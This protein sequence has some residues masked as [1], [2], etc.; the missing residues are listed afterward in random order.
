MGACCDS[1]QVVDQSQQKKKEIGGSL[2]SNYA[3]KQL[4]K[5]AIEDDA[6]RKRVEE[7]WV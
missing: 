3:A 2:T 7:I 5:S 1:K 4:S 6:E